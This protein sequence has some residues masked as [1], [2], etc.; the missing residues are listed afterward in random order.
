MQGVG[1]IDVMVVVSIGQKVQDDEA[2]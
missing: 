1:M 2:T